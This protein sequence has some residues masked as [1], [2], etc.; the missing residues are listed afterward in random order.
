MTSFLIND[1]SQLNPINVNNV[2]YPKNKGEVQKI[3]KENDIIS[4]RGSSCSMGGQ[5][6]TE[7]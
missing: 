2:Y 3:V 6:G 5:I 7:N 1:I 4:I